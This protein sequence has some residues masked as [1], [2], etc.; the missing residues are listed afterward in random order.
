MPRQVPPL[1]CSQEDKARLTAI[2]KSRTEDARMVERAK[3]VLA[4]VAGRE[5]RRVARDLGV[6]VPTVTKWCKRF[7]LRGIKGLRDDLR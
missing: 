6:S 4:R 5:I 1:E 2:R 7:S 3:I